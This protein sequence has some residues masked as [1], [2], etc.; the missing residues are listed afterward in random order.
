MRNGPLATRI[1][2][3][4]VLAFCWLVPFTYGPTQVVTQSLVVWTAAVLWWA[5]WIFELANKRS[6]VNSAPVAWLLAAAFSAV[7][8]LLQYIGTAEI[9][10]PLINYVQ[11][12]QAYANL[13]QRNQLATLLAIGCSALLWLQTR[14]MPNRVA[15]VC[16][17]L[18]VAADA[19]TGSR[20]GLL[21]LLLLLALAVI[22][23]R[24]RLTM[25]I[26]MLG[27]AIAAVLLPITANLDPMQ[28]GILGRVEQ[29]PAGC[30]SRL[31]LWSN[32]IGRAHV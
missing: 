6:K 2:A 18:L 15:A 4:G 12:G 21:Q 5:F 1:C 29:A 27:Y 17:G 26:A 31:T 25:S 3:T 32:E 30:S 24:A 28:S 23:R 7:M 10:N 22:W 11:A 19:A 20:T 8:G 14:A 9:F 16:L 13:R